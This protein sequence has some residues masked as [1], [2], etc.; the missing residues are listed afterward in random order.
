MDKYPGAEVRGVRIKV[1]DEIIY[2]SVDDENFSD[3]IIFGGIFL[4][5]PQG[6][7]QKTYT[8]KPKKNPFGPLG[9]AIQNS[10]LGACDVYNH[11]VVVLDKEDGTYQTE[12]GSEGRLEGQFYRPISIYT[13]EGIWYVGDYYSIQLFNNEGLCFQRI[14]EW[15]NEKFNKIRG[16]CILQGYLCVSDGA[17]KRILVFGPDYAS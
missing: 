12:W 5:N 10:S 11:R 14:E 16:I 3:K 13:W 4:Y 2:V 7:L 15:E 8:V 9:M 1:Q 17:N 6:I